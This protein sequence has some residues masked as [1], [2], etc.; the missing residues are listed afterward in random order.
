MGTIYTTLK[1]RNPV[2][3]SEIVEL[4]AKVDTGAT[5]LVLPESTALHFYLWLE[6]G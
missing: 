3:N 6:I 2:S 1:I 4:E 5:L